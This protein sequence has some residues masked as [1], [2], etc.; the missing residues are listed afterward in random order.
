MT[1][2]PDAEQQRGHLKRLRAALES[3]DAPNAL[4]LLRLLRMSGLNDP[5]SAQI[6]R[7]LSDQPSPEDF[8]AATHWCD[9]HLERLA[10]A[11]EANIFDDLDLLG[12]LDDLVSLDEFDD[13]ETVGDAEMIQIEDIDDMDD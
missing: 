3:R 2:A 1:Q 10:P 6:I 12:D 9:Q 7:A 4:A 8:S 11:V 13:L 5:E